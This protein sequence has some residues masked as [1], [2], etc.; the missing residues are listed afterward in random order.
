MRWF[1]K[2]RIEWI[3]KRVGTMEPTM[4][5]NR[6]DIMRQFEVS[7]VQASKDLQTFQRMFPGTIWYDS[8]DKCY[9]RVSNVEMSE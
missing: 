4:R 6:S 2:E 3:A 7:E 8:H 9:R 5:L 1:E